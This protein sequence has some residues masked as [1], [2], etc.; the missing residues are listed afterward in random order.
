MVGLSRVIQQLGAS[1]RLR[2]TSSMEGHGDRLSMVLPSNVTNGGL[3]RSNTNDRYTTRLATSLRFEPGEWEVALTRFSY[4]NTWHNVDEGRVAW[5]LV[6]GDITVQRSD[7]IPKGRYST[8]DEVVT[9]IMYLFHDNSIAG[10]AQIVY[11]NVLNS[12][13]V[14]VDKT[15]SRLTFSNDV[16]QICGFP[17]GVEVACDSVVRSTR[18]PD[19]QRGLTSLF[20][21]S[22]V[23][24]KR[25]VGDVNVNLLAIVPVSGARFDNVSHQFVR[26]Q[27]VGV[28]PGVIRKIEVVVRRDDGTAVRFKSGKTIAELEF[29]RVKKR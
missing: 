9:A 14:G 15:L 28:E 17:E 22:D 16:C 29:R 5:T 20:V 1:I 4:G 25:A 19:I 21:Y 7:N 18:V 3:H 2:V 24:E 8:V 11:D 10:H 6:N 23:C 12:V 13:G 27:F 26:P